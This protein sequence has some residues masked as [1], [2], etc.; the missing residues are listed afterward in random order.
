MAGT[1]LVFFGGGEG[2]EGWCSNQSEEQKA[3]RGP[4]EVQ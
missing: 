2:R 4:G 3:K 1:L